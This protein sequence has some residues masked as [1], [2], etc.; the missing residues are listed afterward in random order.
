MPQLLAE[1]LVG[2]G[3]ALA[4]HDGATWMI[5]GALPGE[6][7]VASELRRRAGI[8]EAR[9][10]QVVAD[11]HPARSDDPC[12]H[13]PGCGGCDWPYVEAAAGARLKAS[14]A[15]EA[16]RSFPELAARLATAPVKSSPLAY[17]LRA[18]LHWDPK[19]GYLG[20]YQ[21]R[22]WQVSPIPECRIISPRLSQA[23]P[24]LAGAL[25][26]SCPAAADLEWLED[27]DGGAAVMAMRPSRQGPDDVDPAWVPADEG[28]TGVSDGCHSLTRSGQVQPGWGQ[29]SVVMALPVPLKVPVGAFFQGNRHLAPW[30]YERVAE[31]V[32]A[33]PV[34]TWDLHAGVGFLAA[35]A[36]HAAARE[37]TLVE[38]FRPAARA[39]A[40]NLPDARVVVGRS[41]ESYFRRR[42]RLPEAALVLTDPPRA[43]M[44]SSLCRSLAGWHPSR[45]IMLAC[46]PATWARDAAFLTSRG[47]ALSHL[48]LIDLFPSTHHVEVLAVLDST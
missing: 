27:L 3:R 46:D 36:A 4:H 15:S 45:L 2:G 11:A 28:L 29:E 13:A 5:E 21:A 48:E 23:M 34:A 16:A 33:E 9:T 18:R 19:T 12:L 8:V 35:A 47:Y 14:V 30:L 1:R 20:F 25:A 17:R 42:R 32:G 44:S 10:D 6:T 41:A 7:V 22:S 24:S 26:E 40:E 43:G 31:L 37:L 38:T 39:A